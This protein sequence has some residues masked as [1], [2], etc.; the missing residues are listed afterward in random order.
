ME[1]ASKKY[2]LYWRF[3]LNGKLDEMKKDISDFLHGKN[4]WSVQMLLTFFNDLS[5]ASATIIIIPSLK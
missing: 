2:P 1:E 5:F 3:D 4:F